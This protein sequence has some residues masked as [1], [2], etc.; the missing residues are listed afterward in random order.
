MKTITQI[1]NKENI[2]KK[3]NRLSWQII[4]KNT[5]YEEIFIVGIKGNGFLI[6]KRISKIL[7]KNSEFKIYLSEF[8]MDKKKPD[9]TKNFIKPYHKINYSQIP[10]IIIDDV[11]NSGKTLVYSL[12]FFI[13]LYACNIKIVTLIDRKHRLFPIKSDFSGL[14]L[15]TSIKNHVEVIL[16]KN[17]GVYIK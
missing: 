3:I 10:I 9:L 13:K 7:K 14:N 15:S 4:E 6:A 11:I 16:G 17:E 12:N 2:S 8:I 5:K 1:L